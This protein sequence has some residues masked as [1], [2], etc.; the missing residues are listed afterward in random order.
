[1]S[2]TSLQGNSTCANN[3]TGFVSLTSTN[4][5]EPVTYSWSNGDTTAN[6]T[7]LGAGIYSVTVADA[8]GCFATQSF[9]ITS[10]DPIVIHLDTVITITQT[11]GAIHVTVSGG[12]GPYQFQ[13]T[14]PDGS[15][16]SGSEDL[17]NLLLPGNYQLMV[18]DGNGCVFLS[19][20]I[21]VDMDVAVDY[22]ER[23]KSL[24]VYPVPA[25]DVLIVE[26]ENPMTD[27]LISGVDGRLFK[28]FD[29]PV[30]NHLDVSDLQSGWYIIRIT[31]GRS[32]Y[33][34]RIVK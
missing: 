14:L 25:D 18:T 4:A 20:T 1:L 5:I 22:A 30:S 3:P 34:A 21:P 15:Q 24:K 13:W 28:R 9:T 10:P 12:V 6:V 8:T 31:D 32:W 33:I 7:N 19:A 2:I 17:D 23:F 16:L 26:M 27:V 29:H 11:A